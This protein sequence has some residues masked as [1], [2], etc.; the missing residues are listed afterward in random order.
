M[1]PRI[2]LF[3]TPHRINTHTHT[4]MNVL[5]RFYTVSG[6]IVTYWPFQLLSMLKWA[7]SQMGWEIQL[8]FAKQWLAE[9]LLFDCRFPMFGFSWLYLLTLKEV[10]RTFIQSFSYLLLF[11]LIRLGGGWGL[12][13]LTL[14]GWPGKPWTDHQCITGL[15]QEQQSKIVFVLCGWINHN[16]DAS[17]AFLILS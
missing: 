4:V 2:S 14:G 15:H 17:C 9:N 12:S 8:K 11:I 7:G 5:S 1:L 13:Q 6:S 10:P 16:K 3:Y